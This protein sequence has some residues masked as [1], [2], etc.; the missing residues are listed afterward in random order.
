MRILYIGDIVGRP[1]RHCVARQL[2]RLRE[3]N[4]VDFVIANAENA[5]GGMGATPES[6]RELQAL[7]IHAFTMGNHIWRKDE[8]ISALDALPD[9]VRPANYPAGAPGRGT[10]LVTLP[11][12]RVVGVLNLLGR[13]FM[14]PLDCPFAAA[15]R[16][17]AALRAH[18]PVIVTDMHAE[19]TSEKV[20]MGWHLDGRCT[21]VVGS[22]THVQTADEWVLPQGTAY[23]SD[24]GMCGPMYSVIGVRS[25]RVLE[26]FRTGMPRKFEVAK[27]PAI[28][29]AVLIDADEATGKA[30]EIRRIL[31][32]DA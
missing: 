3:E 9:V 19:A 21:A 13:V 10:A 7:G 5:A 29:C 8:L 22:H 14:A 4:G 28:F 17:I 18:T 30:R 11:D 16:E 31:I 1:G 2:P 12:G 6:L 27:G 24:V 25:D 32:R 26:R 20:A 15:D 23:I